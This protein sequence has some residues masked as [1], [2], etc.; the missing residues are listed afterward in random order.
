MSIISI[1]ILF[2]GIGTFMALMASAAPDSDAIPWPILRKGIWA[3]S[4][5]IEATDQ[6]LK[7]FPE[8]LTNECHSPDAEM[9]AKEKSL[10]KNGCKIKLLS[11]IG[12]NITIIEACP[13]HQADTQATKVTVV[14]ESKSSS[15]LKVTSISKNMKIT[16]LGRWVRDCPTK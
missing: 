3:I 5:D 11:K 8:S 15:D 7:R 10:E 6:Q 12:N 13:D 1:K 4:Q 14:L 16:M 9:R 2:I